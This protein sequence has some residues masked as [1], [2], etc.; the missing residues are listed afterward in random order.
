MQKSGYTRDFQAKEKE[1]SPE[2]RNA[3]RINLRAV[4]L[5]NSVHSIVFSI[6]TAIGDELDAIRKNVLR[7][8]VTVAYG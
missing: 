1:V 8:A 3:F 4:S 2:K 5:Q 7:K 6:E